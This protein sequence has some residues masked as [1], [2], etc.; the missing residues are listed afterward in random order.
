MGESVDCVD[1]WGERW[2][3][4]GWISRSRLANGALRGFQ[5]PLLTAL[6]AFACLYAR[7]S[8]H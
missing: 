8:P 6:P 5:A 3:M 1:Y 4:D 2:G 7:E